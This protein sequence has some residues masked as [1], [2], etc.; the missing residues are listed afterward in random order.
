MKQ[1]VFASNNPG[2]IKEFSQIFANLDI[3]IIPQSQLDVPEIDEPFTTFIENALHKARH[4]TKST[5]FPSLADD[6]GL[7]VTALHGA[8]GIRSARYAG[9]PQNDL[10]NNQK[11]IQALTSIEDKSASYHCTLVLMQCEL[12][13]TP[14]I[15]QGKLDGIIILDARG[16]NGFGYDPHFY[17]EQYGK[18]TAELDAEIKNKISHRAK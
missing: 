12:D 6:S 15:A 8:P 9:T 1:I 11:L 14:I 5:G 18:T 4:C 13:P 3:E 2:K 17:L 10:K 16:K 7:C